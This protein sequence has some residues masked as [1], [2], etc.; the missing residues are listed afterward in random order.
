[1]K[2]QSINLYDFN[3]II[4]NFWGIK[5]ER[6]K[7]TKVMLVQVWSGRWVIFFYLRFKLKLC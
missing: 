1:M 7:K 6:K 3:I 2:S 5:K 4:S